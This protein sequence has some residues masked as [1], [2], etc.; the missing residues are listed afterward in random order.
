MT[1]RYYPEHAPE[2]MQSFYDFVR[3]QTSAPV[4]WAK[5]GAPGLTKPFV[6]VDMIV[7]P[8]ANGQAEHRNYVAVVVDEVLDG[9][10][11]A[12]IINDVVYS[13][14]SG[15][16]ATDVQIRDALIEAINNGGV[17]EAVGI[18]DSTLAIVT[19]FGQNEPT[20]TFYGGLLLKLA[21][22]AL[23]DAVATFAVDV[24]TNDDS[25]P[26]VAKA[27]ELGLDK[28]SALEMLSAAGWGTVSVEGV[29][30]PDNLSGTGWEKRGGFDLRLRCRT[31]A[32]DLIDFIEEAA[33]T[34]TTA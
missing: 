19:D 20:I 34:G 33:F 12:V 28:T 27:I 16:D 21:E 24:F 22:Y 5:Q 14:E 9:E 25:A 8:V 7:P 18:S 29:R 10:E 15:E 13:I 17:V 30:S 26:A 2:M 31:R 32:L 23:C 4:A 11:Y 1:A 3:S 6:L